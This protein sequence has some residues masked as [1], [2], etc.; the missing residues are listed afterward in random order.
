MQEAKTQTLPGTQEPALWALPQ[1]PE[2]GLGECAVREQQEVA[3]GP[4]T[5]ARPS[6]KWV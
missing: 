3:P 2:T 1:H 6:E 4:A 5:A